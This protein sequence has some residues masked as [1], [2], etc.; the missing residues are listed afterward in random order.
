MTYDPADRTPCD[1][2]GRPPLICKNELGDTIRVDA[3]FKGAIAG[4]GSNGCC[5]HGNRDD[6]YVRLEVRD[7]NG[8]PRTVDLCGFV[9]QPI[10]CHGARQEADGQWYSGDGHHKI[11][12]AEYVPAENA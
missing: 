7:E 5:G 8:K 6:A 11:R 3:C 4:F 10:G 12:W 9:V 1:H 2:C